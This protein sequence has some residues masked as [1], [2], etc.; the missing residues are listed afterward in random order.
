MLQIK[1]KACLIIA[2]LVI[3]TGTKTA[4]AEAIE[5]A[6]L[7][8][9]ELRAFTEVLDRIKKSYVE[10]VDDKTLLENAIKGMLS[11]LDPHSAYLQPKEYSKLQVN[12]SGEFG[13]LG[14][15]VGMENGFIKV[16]SPID[17][18]PAHK[19]GIKSGD[20]IIKLDSTLVKGLT[21]SEAVNKMRGKPGTEIILTIIREQAHKPLEISV[22]RAAI[23]VKSVRYRTLEE[24]F[25]YLRIAQFQVNT[26][27]DLKYAFDKLFSENK[28]LKGIILDLR[29]N[30]G[31]VLH[32]AVDVTNAF[33][34]EGLIVYT[35]GRREDSELKFSANSE[36]ISVD[37]PLIILVNGGS[38]SASEIVAGALQDHKRAILL[39]TQTFGKGSV[40]TVLPLPNDRA[41]KLTTARYYTP[42]GRT[43]QAKGIKPDIIVDAAKLT[44]INHKKAFKESDLEGHLK[45][46]DKVKT[47]NQDNGTSKTDS[48]SLL[49][50]DY[51]LHEAFQLLKGLSI[52]KDQ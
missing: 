6:T 18:T 37:T 8:L 49:N 9:E 14:I 24:G 44:K 51:Q 30:P 35:K 42:N 40:Q 16:I 4:Y 46:E 20:L 3:L 13:G 31:G 48:L 25:V 11:E 21:L 32:A 34:D 15:E 2:T 5:Q 43:I 27:S 17:D 23:K 7:P 47:A 41:I 19:A 12:T 52:L 50:E 39:G 29:N 28:E 22:T 33:I 36:S 26:G 45:N 10:E 1:N 38:A